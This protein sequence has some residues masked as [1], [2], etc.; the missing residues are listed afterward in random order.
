MPR[1]HF[2]TTEEYIDIFPK[3]TQAILEEIRKL[4][5]KMVPEATEKISYNIPSFQL[6]G[7]YLIYYAA[8]KRHIGVYPIPAG[9]KAFEER[10]TPYVHGR[11]TLRFDLEKP[12]PYDLIE[13]VIK[14]SIQRNRSK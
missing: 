14:Y 12:I 1:Q 10:I 3:E 8:Y 4:V 6:D 9:S 13:E 2:E 7:K 11:G 5:K